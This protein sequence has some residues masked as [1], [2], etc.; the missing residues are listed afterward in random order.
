MTKENLFKQLLSDPKFGP[1]VVD[2]ANSQLI[3]GEA[4]ES[5]RGFLSSRLG[6]VEGFFVNKVLFNREV[7]LT[8][9]QKARLTTNTGVT[10]TS[11][12][13]ITRWALEYMRSASMVDLMGVKSVNFPSQLK[14]LE[15][16]NNNNYTLLASNNPILAVVNQISPWTLSLAGKKVLVINPFIDDI[17]S[18]YEK[19]SSIPFIDELLPTFEL[20]GLM[21]PVTTSVDAISPEDFERSLYQLKLQV[22]E[23]DF[24]VAIIGAGGYGLSIAAFIKELGKVALHIGGLTQLIFGVTGAR[25]DD[26]GWMNAVDKRGWIRPTMNEDNKHAFNIAK[27]VYV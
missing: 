20:I 17:K 1:R 8:S 2:L 9:K 6:N 10:D 25:W 11:F 19:K 13:G 27:G 22:L 23:L 26:A 12:D 24:D 14:L 4:I 3:M 7:D 18:Q 16:T 5:G 15:Y 21:P